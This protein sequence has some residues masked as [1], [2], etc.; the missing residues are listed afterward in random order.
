MCISYKYFRILC[1]FFDFHFSSFS[2]FV[3][4]LKYFCP[5][6]LRICLGTRTIFMSACFSLPETIFILVL[7]LYCVFLNR[8]DVKWKMIQWFYEQLC[9]LYR[10]SSRCRC[11][12]FLWL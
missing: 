5:V 6:Y 7:S 8:D 9:F 11:F 2:A 3:D 1:V 12:F 4:N 10:G